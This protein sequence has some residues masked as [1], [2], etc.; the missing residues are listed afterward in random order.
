MECGGLQTALEAAAL[1]MAPP[2]QQAGVWGCHC[3]Q[4]LAVLMGPWYL[5]M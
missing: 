5:A 2:W 4:G 1:E 3:V